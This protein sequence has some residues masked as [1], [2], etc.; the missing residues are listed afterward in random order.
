MFYYEGW[1]DPRKPGD[2]YVAVADDKYIIE[3]VKT[4][5]G[6]FGDIVFIFTSPTGSEVRLGRA[7][8]KAAYKVYMDPWASQKAWAKE[9]GFKFVMPDEAAHKEKG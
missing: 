5:N 8:L 1:D 7:Q 3:Y 9:F 4:E 6:F 2:Q